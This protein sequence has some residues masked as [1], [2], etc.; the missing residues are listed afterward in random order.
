MKRISPEV[1]KIIFDTVDEVMGSFPVLAKSVR[2][3]EDY[4]GNPMIVVEASY[5]LR[6][7]PASGRDRLRLLVALG[8][9]LVAIEDFRQIDL[10]ESFGPGQTFRVLGKVYATQ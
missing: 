5:G 8:N 10:R 7:E 4:E 2:P 9:R 6:Q 3:G 1:E